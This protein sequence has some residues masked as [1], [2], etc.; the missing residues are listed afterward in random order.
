MRGDGDALNAIALHP[1][2]R[3]LAVGDDDGTVVFLDAVTRRRLGTPYQ[4][5]GASP[6]ISALA[7]SPDGTR[8]A[9]AA[10]D[11]SMAVVDLFDGRTR[12]HIAQVANFPSD[13]EATVHFSP[14]SRVLAAEDGH[15]DGTPGRVPRW[16]AREV[17]SR[18]PGPRRRSNR[19]R[20]CSDSSTRERDS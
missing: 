1:D 16:D 8:L 9:S 19:H 13:A 12:R 10:W 5:S 4:V 20:P 11:R 7:F 14:D 17:G 6:R 18:C 2:G 15:A 3:T